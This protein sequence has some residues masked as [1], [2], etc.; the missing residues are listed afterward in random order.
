MLVGILLALASSVTAI[1]IGPI[2]IGGP[3][4]PS[5]RKIV[6]TNDDGW[7]TAQMRA[8]LDALIAE[9]YDVRS[10]FVSLVIPVTLM[11]ML[12][13]WLGRHVRHVRKP[14]WLELEERNAHRAEPNLRVW[15][16]RH[17]VACDGN[18]RFQQCVHASSLSFT[19]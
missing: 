8:Q 10:F 15:N 18:E 1:S 2:S 5:V 14:V 19:Y 4:R 11:R 9:G 17:R 6:L 13:L 16:V 7:A 12:G 3:G